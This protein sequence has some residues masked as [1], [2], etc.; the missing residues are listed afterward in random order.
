MINEK[1]CCS[2]EYFEITLY[3]T[4]KLIQTYLMS[5]DEKDILNKRFL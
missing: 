5:F 1:N 2:I 3:D 4:L